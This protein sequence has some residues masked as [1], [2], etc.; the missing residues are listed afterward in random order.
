MEAFSRRLGVFLCKE[1]DGD[2]RIETSR[3]LASVVY[4]VC[5]KAF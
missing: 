1:K 4:G 3:C 2:G 5:Y